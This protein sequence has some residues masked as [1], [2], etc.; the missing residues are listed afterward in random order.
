MLHALSR[1]FTLLV[2]R[3]LPDAYLFVILLTF[4]TYSSIYLHQIF[5]P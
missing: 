5:L 1:F 4:V 3:Y 2:K